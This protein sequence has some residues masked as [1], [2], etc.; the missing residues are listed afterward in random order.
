MFMG[1]LNFTNIVVN[2]R[3]WIVQICLS[4]ARMYEGHDTPT[5]SEKNLMSSFQFSVFN[6][7]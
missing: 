2:A 3:A 7:F 6:V 1:E 5:S 4:M